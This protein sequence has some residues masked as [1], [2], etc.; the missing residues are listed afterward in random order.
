MPLALLAAASGARTMSGLAAIAPGNA[1]RRA[2]R[3]L[4]VG[5]LIADKLPNVPDRVDPALIL[6]RVAAGALVGALVGKQTGRNRGTF[7]LVGGLVAFAS[8]HATYRLRR[9]L[10][11]RLPAL[12]AALVEDSIVVGATAAASALLRSTRRRSSQ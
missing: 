6:G 12:A 11:Q 8:T 2:T 4:A 5:E 1:A 9:A 10:S 7:A 3:V